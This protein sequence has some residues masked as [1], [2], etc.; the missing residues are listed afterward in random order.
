MSKDDGY[1]AILTTPIPQLYIAA[2]VD[3]VKKAVTHIDFLQGEHTPF[4]AH[5]PFA[6]KLVWE[7]TRY[8]DNAHARF[9][10]QVISDGSEFQQRVWDALNTIPVGEVLTYGQLAARLKTS[11]RAVGRAC[12]TNPVALIVPC[13][14]VVGQHGYGGYAGDSDGSLLAFKKWL[15]MH[16]QG[17][18]E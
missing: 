7:I 17:S 1:Q 3:A 12:R 13:H 14:R 9:S 6:E 2:K 18:A 5:E 10:V 11:A 16:E 4:V 8:L 15:L